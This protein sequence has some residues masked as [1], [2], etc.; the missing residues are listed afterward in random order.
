L[1]VEERFEVSSPRERVYALLNDVAEIGLCVAGVQ[2]IEVVDETRSRWRIEQRFGFIARTFT[3]DAQITARD[4]LTRVAFV[5]ADREVSIT[6]HVALAA[7]EDGRTECAIE[8]DID[9]S[10]PLAPLVEIF[11]KGPQEA[12]IRQTLANLRERLEA[13][14]EPVAAG[15]GAG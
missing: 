8:L 7:A 4:P 14:R 12:L 15:G 2:S 10:G 9:V 5:A 6:G 3:L 1:R 13:A 11:A